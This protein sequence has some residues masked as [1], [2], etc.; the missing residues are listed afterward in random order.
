MIRDYIVQNPDGISRGPTS[1]Q[2]SIFQGR[3]VSP[4]VKCS[5]L[6][7]LW[8]SCVITQIDPFDRDILLGNHFGEGMIHQAALCRSRPREAIGEVG[9]FEQVQLSGYLLGDS[10]RDGVAGVAVGEIPVKRRVFEQSGDV[11]EAMNSIAQG[12]RPWAW[13]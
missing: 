10:G 5:A 8:D 7:I 1:R 12:R 4:G 13:E 9:R 6:E 11:Y 3:N 2:P